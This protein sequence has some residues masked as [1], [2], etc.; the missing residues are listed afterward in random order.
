MCQRG[1]SSK[2][3]VDMRRCASKDVGSQRGVDLVGSHIDWRKERVPARILG[4]E[5]GW[6]IR[7]HI[8]WGGE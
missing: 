2:K 8:G 7:S 5:R 1:G 4:S 6:I 3:G